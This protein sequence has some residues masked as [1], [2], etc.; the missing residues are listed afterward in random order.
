MLVDRELV[1]PGYLHHTFE[2][3]DCK[4]PETRLLFA[5]ERPLPVAPAP[6]H[7]PEMPSISAWEQ[8]IAKLRN[9]QLVLSTKAEIRR[10]SERAAEFNRQWDH[11]LPRRKAKPGVRPRPDASS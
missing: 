11:L 3:A 2:C 7:E 8:A 6:R 1:V 5:R 10:A 4:E 9:H